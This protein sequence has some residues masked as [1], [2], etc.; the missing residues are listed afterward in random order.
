M[1]IVNI[2]THLYLVPADSPCVRYEST[3]SD[4]VTI[5]QT[6][7]LSAVQEDNTELVENCI[8]YKEVTAKAWW[9]GYSLY[10]LEPRADSP[11]D[12]QLFI[13]KVHH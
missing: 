8:M 9:L 12:Q 7:R 10:P 2:K 13:E 6:D 4:N 3:T 5:K 11:S 1:Y